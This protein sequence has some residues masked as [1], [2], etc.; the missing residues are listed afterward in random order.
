MDKLGFAKG[1]YNA[2]TFFH[3]TKR[4]KVMIH[5][6]DFVTVGERKEVEWLKGKLGE[7]F[8]V[9]NK[10]L[11]KGVGVSKEETILNRI[12]RVT[13]GGREYE[14]DQR[15]GEI[16]VKAMHMDEAKPAQTA[17]EDDK[18]WEEA[19]D[20]EELSEAQGKEY[21]QLARGRII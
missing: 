16:I 7:R 1:K 21:R 19:E 10:V 2:C 6:D 15:H 14:A 3:A 20:A 12:V 9:K 13:E 8:E 17:G 5:G 11:G 4:L 18:S